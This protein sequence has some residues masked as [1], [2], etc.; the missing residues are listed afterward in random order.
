MVAILFSVRRENSAKKAGTGTGPESGRSRQV[1]SDGLPA[2]GVATH[3]VAATLGVWNRENL[4]V[5]WPSG[6][7]DDVPLFI[8]FWS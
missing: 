7:M 6:G 2:R 1:D 8:A 4:S 3:R 5:R